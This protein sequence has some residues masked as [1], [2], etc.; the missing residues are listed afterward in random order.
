M[1]PHS[2]TKRCPKCGELKPATPECF[3]RNRA[4]SDGFCCYCKVCMSAM[5]QARAARKME[6]DRAWRQAHPERW[7]E[8]RRA[9]SWRRKVARAQE[10]RV[11]RA[12]NPERR[13]EHRRARKLLER[14]ASGHHGERQW[15]AL[16]RKH[17]Y[18]CLCCG[19]REPEIE[20][21]RDHILPLTQGGSDGIEN[22]Q[23]L[24]RS[25]N[26]SKGASYVDFR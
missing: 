4:A 2:T 5:Q 25:C 12:K 23:P 21:T 16:K 11:W 14:G 15:Q 22:I 8:L 6:T 10:L 3:Y 1:H 26:S 24:C 18:T 9:D 17:D 13:N 7:R 19:K 20:L